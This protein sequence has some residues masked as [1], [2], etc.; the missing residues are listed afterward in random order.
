LRIKKIR[1]SNGT[2]FKNSQIEGFLEKEGI[3]DE[4]SSPYTPQ[5]NG[6]VARKNRT[7]LDM[8]RIMLEEYKIS[9]RFWVDAINTACYSIN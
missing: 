3:K 5:R 8:A 4:F 9:D 2:E 1:R 7:L 6:I